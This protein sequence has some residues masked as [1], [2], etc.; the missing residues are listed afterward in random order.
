MEKEEMGNELS[1]EACHKMIMEL[2][3][4][5]AQ[6]EGA[7]SEVQDVEPKDF[8]KKAKVTNDDDDD[9]D[10]DDDEESEKV[11]MKEPKDDGELKKPEGGELKKP[12]DK[13]DYYGMDSHMK[14]EFLKEISERDEL[15]DKLSNIIGVFDHADKT[16]DEVAE[17][18]VK[19]LGLR[20]KKGHEAS[21]LQGYLAAK[22][23]SIPQHTMDT[24]E[25][26]SCVDAFL[27]AANQG[28]L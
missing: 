16:L 26:N 22:T 7:K 21:V 19:E 3:E 17:Y 8:V 25:S 1:L 27:K 9:M 23:S 24:K 6:L 5:V 14:K 12:K 11:E 20:C 2:K 18:G 13:K 10:D 15:A 28:G 4:K